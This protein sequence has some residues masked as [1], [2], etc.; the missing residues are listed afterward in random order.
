V[1]VVGRGRRRRRRRRS[2][3]RREGRRRSSAAVLAGIISGGGDVVRRRHVA[4]LSA[5]D[6]DSRGA[7]LAFDKE[8]LVI[9]PEGGWRSKQQLRAREREAR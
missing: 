2:R 5:S 1:E 9:S 6:F 3:R 7:L 4:L 8:V